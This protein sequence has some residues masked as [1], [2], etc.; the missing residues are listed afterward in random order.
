[1]NKTD[2]TMKA[3]LAS[4]CLLCAQQAQAQTLDWRAYGG[5]F[6]QNSWA[7]SNGFTSATWLMLQP[8]LGKGRVRVGGHAM[9]SADPLLNGECGQ[10][11]FL[12][13]DGPCGITTSM[14]HPLVM[15]LGVHTAFQ[16][17]DVRLGFQA[18]A[19]GEPAFGPHTYFMRASAQHDPAP[20]LTHH[21]FNPAH[22]AH[23]VVTASVA[24][25]GLQFEASLFNARPVNDLYD[26]RI[27]SL[28]AQAAR[29]SFTTSSALRLQASAARFPDV[30]GHHGHSGE[31]QA[32]S[33]TAD[34]ALRDNLFYTAGCAAH[35]VMGETPKACFAEATLATGIHLFSARAEA[36]DRLEQD[37]IVEILPDGTHSHTAFNVMMQASEFTVGYGVRFPALRGLQSSL[38]IRASIIPLSSELRNR[39]QEK[40]ATSL[41][42]FLSARPAGAAGHH[43]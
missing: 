25:R 34:G 21:F 38:G 39:Y 42:V 11:R 43:H 4:L 17:T 15:M 10:P 14:S 5:Y 23:G 24:R 6:Q 40:R 22:S 30:G 13:E 9:L 32:Y 7:G 18:S 31:M 37:A 36:A 41:M 26:I 35:H 8:E 29:V 19:V 20:P 1:V 3:A 27:G 28:H 12:P 16:L 2:R 33:L